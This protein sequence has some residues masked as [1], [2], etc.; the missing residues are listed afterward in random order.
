MRKRLFEVEYQDLDERVFHRYFYVHSIQE[1]LDKFYS[2]R[3]GLYYKVLRVTLTQITY[4]E[5]GGAE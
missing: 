5:E 1:A 4:A 2:T 3:D